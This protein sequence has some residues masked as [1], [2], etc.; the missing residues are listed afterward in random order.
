MF[1]LDISPREP[2]M[3]CTSERDEHK[4]TCQV[5]F[6]E[7]NNLPRE[8]TLKEIRVPIAPNNVIVMK[9][10]KNCFFLTWNLLRKEREKKEQ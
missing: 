7:E 10:R 6:K 4:R 2:V 5:K 1:S 9:L 3:E 8:I